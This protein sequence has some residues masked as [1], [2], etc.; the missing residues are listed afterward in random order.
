[1]IGFGEFL[2]E[3]F[4]TLKDA[5]SK[6]SVAEEIWKLLEL[7]YTEIGGLM[8]ANKDD[9]IETKGMWKLVRKNGKIVAGVVYK[10]M[11]GSRKIRLVLHD[12]TPEGKTAVKK[13]I[14]EDIRFDRS[15]AR[16]LVRLNV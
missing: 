8:G 16:C 1:M 15:W 4:V 13:I 6:R 5:S 2:T 3:R 10:D 9:L 14:E 12:G 7:T 11:H